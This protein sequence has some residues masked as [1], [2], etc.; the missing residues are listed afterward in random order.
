[1]SKSKTSQEILTRIVSM[2]N[3]DS[4]ELRAASATV[5]AD[6]AP[7]DA[8]TLDALR[9]A[10]GRED[11]ALLRK[12]AARALGEIAPKSIV[13]DLQAL[14]KDPDAEVRAMVKHVLASGRG[15]TAA[16]V[17][18]MLESKDD[19]QR[20]SALAVLGAMGT[21]EARRSILTQLSCG[22][23]RIYEAIRDAMVPILEGL[24]AAE[25][26]DAAGEIAG[27]MQPSLY[28]AD[29]KLGHTLVA[30]LAAVPHEDTATP[31]LELAG[32]RAKD[33]VRAAAV[34]A[35]RGGAV[36]GKKL[37]QRVFGSLLEL[38]EAEGTG[39][40][41]VKSTTDTLTTL[42]VPLAL[43]SRVRRLLSVKEA[44]IRRWALKALGRLDSAPAGKAL[45]DA[46]AEGDPTD[47]EVALAAAVATNSG[48][49]ALARLLGKLTDTARAEAVASALRPHLD[50]LQQATLHHLEESALDAS[51]EV[52]GVVMNLLKR[53]GSGNA[54]RAH[55]G[56]FDKAVK[57]KSDGRYHDAADIFKRMAAGS[58]DAESRFQLGVCEL[59][60]SKRKLTRGARKDPC[61]TTLSGLQRVRDF[62]LLARIKDEAGIGEEELYYIGFSLAEGGD[63]EQGLGGDLLMAIVESK[64]ES[65]LHQM[66]KN[67][68]VTMGWME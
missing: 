35:L 43:E 17:A 51:P 44:L 33:P 36:E 8:H 16:D 59:M 47:R 13:K 58:T 37:S 63:D 23:P 41:I 18:R 3:H 20:V 38:L 50:T 62:P 2:L 9:K 11:D 39:R 32:S 19:K 55:D 21:P 57:L 53:S 65:K 28:V 66:A 26:E 10:L 54:G 22:S 24:S 56:L 45:A 29:A 14:L 68:L 25:Q 6:L 48:K 49:N 4:A 42:D 15:V 60:Q 52:A 30:L 7:G 40:A 27:A 5:L 46:V 61:L 34:D 67:K 12:N 64:S 31:L 1:M